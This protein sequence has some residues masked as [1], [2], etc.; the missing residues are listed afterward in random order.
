[1]Q[2]YTRNR[3]PV[4]LDLTHNLWAMTR[5]LTCDVN[6]VIWMLLNEFLDAGFHARPK[7]L[8]RAHEVTLHFPSQYWQV[9]SQINFPFRLSH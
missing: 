2:L 3:T 1:M 6:L 9:K 5:D 4:T 7:R 8:E